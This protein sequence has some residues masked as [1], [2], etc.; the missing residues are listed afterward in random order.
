MA[1]GISLIVYPVKDIA[2]A[3]AIYTKL[4]GVEPYMENPYYAGFRV[5]DQE[6]GLDPNGHA[7]GLTGPLCYSSVTDLEKSLQGLLDAGARLHQ[8]IK[9][10]GGGR[11]IALVKD[12][13]D[14]L[15]GLVQAS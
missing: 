3:K 11:R 8:A 4:L 7:Q 1:Q 5:M 14:N 15:I 6:I 9:E 10:V 13:D 12:A 2:K